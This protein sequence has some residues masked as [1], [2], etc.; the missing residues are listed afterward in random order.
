MQVIEAWAGWQASGLLTGP[1]HDQAM[2]FMLEVA[3]TLHEAGLVGVGP[4]LPS[5]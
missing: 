3:D 1:L 5:A 2:A 4:G